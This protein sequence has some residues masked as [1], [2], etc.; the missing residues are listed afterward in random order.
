MSSS[1]DFKILFY[2]TGFGAALTYGSWH[3]IKR[4]NKVRDTAKQLISSAS[5]GEVEVEAVAWPMER[6]ENCLESK[7][8]L[9]VELKLQE[10][11]GGKKKSW[12]T[13]WNYN[14][15]KPFIAFDQT[16]FV[17]VMPGKDHHIDVHRQK[18]FYPDKMTGEQQVRFNSLY[19][20]QD[21]FNTSSFFGISLLG[22]KFRIQERKLLVGSPVLIHGFFKPEDQIRYVKLNTMLLDFRD[23]CTEILLD[24][25]RRQRFMD[26]NNDGTVTREEL[27]QGFERLLRMSIGEIGEALRLSQEGERQCRYY[28]KIF[29]GESE[30]LHVADTFEEQYLTSKSSFFAWVSFSGG[31]FCFLL[32]LYLL[33]KH[34]NT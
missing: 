26:R 5:A 15:S 8:C 21:I 25:G 12:Q 13:I 31:M 32:G 6:V 3:R 29:G 28:G 19:G 10:L 34:F 4:I 24:P 20:G 16:G 1:D 33:A 18:T 27:G 7:K 11:K 14:F 23:K 17:T 2:L 30:K 22:R 9:Y